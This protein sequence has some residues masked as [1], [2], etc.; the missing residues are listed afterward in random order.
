MHALLEDT[1]EKYNKGE[2]NITQTLYGEEHA[3]ILS[4]R[5][6]GHQNPLPSTKTTKL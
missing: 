3:G 6:T 2:H 4:G 1:I 5:D